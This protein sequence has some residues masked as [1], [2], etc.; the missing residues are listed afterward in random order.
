MSRPKDLRDDG[1]IVTV[2]VHG[3]TVQDAL[4]IIRRSVQQAHRRGRSRLDVVH[5]FSTSDRFGYERS[6]KNEFRK[7]LDAGEY[8]AWVSGSYEDAS[9]GRTSLAL[10]LGSRPDPTRLK[11]G[12]VAS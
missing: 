4:A 2:D 8:R 11:A 6:I 9:G 3:C 10:N 1:S 12:D 7:R 5:G